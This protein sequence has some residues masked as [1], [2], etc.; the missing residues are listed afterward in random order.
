MR[1]KLTFPDPIFEETF[2]L[3]YQMPGWRCHIVAV[4]CGV[5]KQEVEGGTESLKLDLL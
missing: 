5:L 1:V 4:V 3:D 2:E